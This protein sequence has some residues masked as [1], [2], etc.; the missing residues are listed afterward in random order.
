MKT[1]YYRELVARAKSGEVRIDDVLVGDVWLCAGQPHMARSLN[2]LGVALLGFV[3]VFLAEQACGQTARLKLEVI[4]TLPKP[5]IS[6]ETPGA[7][8][9]PGGFEGGS[10]A[11]VLIDG[12]PQYHFFAHS[13][14]GLTWHRSQLDHWVSDDGR[15]FR[16]ARVL[17]EDHDDKAAGKK[18]VYTAPVPFYVEEEKRWYL[19]YGEFAGSIGKS[20][21]PRTGTMYCAPSSVVGPAGISGPFDFA[22]KRELVSTQANGR[23][24]VSNGNPFQLQDNRW[25][26]MVCPDNIVIKEFGRYSI[27]LSFA[28]S[29]LGPF[30]ATQE[31]VMAPLIEPTGY[32]E[33]P[34][35][36]K[37]KGPKSGRDY[38]VAVFDFLGPELANYTP[39]NVFGF[40]WS[41][42]G[43]HWPREHGQ[44][45][46]IDD[47]LPKG[48]TGW[49][50]GKGAVRTPHQMLDEGDGTYTIFFTGAT[51]EDYFKDFRAVGKLRVRVV[52]E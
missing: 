4:N 19:S 10:S 36:T 37:V 25:A 48:E 33:N 44:A 50:Q 49:W 42:D 6:K 8:K 23:R 21:D 41:E 7:E 5:V 2:L 39:K 14:P 1:N 38:W 22:K 3:L 40:S 24:P 46:L 27:L 43:V 32:I 30:T 34:M 15:Q 28:Q 51:H 17:Q 31:P 52:E 16:H 47:G 18:Y 20:W 12:K 11:R 9:I 35:V 45:V 29:Q 13:Y 26:V